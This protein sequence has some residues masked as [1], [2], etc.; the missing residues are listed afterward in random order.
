M[1]ADS[2]LA[3]LPRGE[4]SLP[5]RVTPEYVRQALVRSRVLVEVDGAWTEPVDGERPLFIISAANPIADPDVGH[6]SLDVNTNDERTDALG[7]E[8]RL[9]GCAPLRAQIVPS[10]GSEPYDA[11][12]VDGLTLRE[13]KAMARRW[14]QDAVLRLGHGVLEAISCQ[15][16]WSR[17]RNLDGS[18][19]ERPPGLDLQSACRKAL[20]RGQVSVRAGGHQSPRPSE[21][22]FS[23]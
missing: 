10:D 16:G 13:A 17:L 12:A 2:R 23:S 5:G 4:D 1:S 7:G 20:V 15:G 9:I 3:A 22:I 11:W 19:T 6:A 14:S 21:R 18:D 8:L